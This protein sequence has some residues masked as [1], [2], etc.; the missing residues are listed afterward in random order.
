MDVNLLA[1][2]LQEVMQLYAELRR[3]YDAL[4]ADYEALLA[5]TQ[6]LIAERDQLQQQVAELRATN[7]QRRGG[8]RSVFWCQVRVRRGITG[9]GKQ[10]NGLAGS[11]VSAQSHQRRDSSKS[12]GTLAAQSPQ[13]N[14]PTEHRTFD[15]TLIHARRA[16]AAGETC[17]T[18]DT[19]SDPEAHL[20][21]RRR[22]LILLSL[23]E[24]RLNAIVEMKAIQIPKL[25][26]VKRLR[27]S[28]LSRWALSS[29][30]FNGLVLFGPPPR[31]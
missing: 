5:T 12:S 19:R 16:N 10:N 25:K 7:K 6:E 30:T 15:A 21:R 11:N 17:E 4:R 23:E 9:S 29:E 8:V 27:L 24:Y 31:G 13:P 18:P 2:Q 20:M 26:I 22:H 1:A 28:H 3:D 14:S